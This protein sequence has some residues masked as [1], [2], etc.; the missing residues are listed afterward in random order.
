MSKALSKLWPILMLLGFLSIGIISLANRPAT[1]ASAVDLL[2]GAYL[3]YASKT[4]CVDPGFFDT[5]DDPA[6]GWPIVDDN[7][8]KTQYLTANGNGL[9]RIAPKEIDT[10]APYYVFFA[11]TNS[12]TDYVVETDIR[13][14]GDP[15]VSVGGIVFSTKPDQSE[16]YLFGIYAN[17]DPDYADYYQKYGVLKYNIQSSELTFLVLPTTSTAIIPGNEFNHLK[18]TLEGDVFTL[19]ING[20]EL[21]T[22]YDPNLNSPS[23]VGVAMTPPDVFVPNQAELRVDNFHVTSCID[24]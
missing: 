5:F 24:N 3:P 1:P 8:V 16:G 13:W 11:P 12:R 4:G 9:Y 23:I 7:W 15:G 2:P 20:V 18:V 10:N 6:S 22:V 19:E 21:D 17:P 14:T